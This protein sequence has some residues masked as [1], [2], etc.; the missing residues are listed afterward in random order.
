M[1]DRNAAWR[2]EF[3]AAG[4]RPFKNQLKTGDESHTP[5]DERMYVGSAQKAFADERGIRYFISVN[6]YDFT[7]HG[8]RRS[9]SADVQFH[10][11]DHGKG[12]CTNVSV[13]VDGTVEAVEVLV[14]TLWNRMGWGYYEVTD[15]RVPAS[16][17]TALAVLPP[18]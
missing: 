9:A 13:A 3:I 6:F 16:N 17:D 5:P 11:L 10:A 7:A 15:D 18:A 4:Y 2:D 12:Q 1:N 14:G 8:G